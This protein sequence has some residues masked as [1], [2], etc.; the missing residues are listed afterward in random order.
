MVQLKDSPIT[1]WHLPALGQHDVA[2]DFAIGNTFEECRTLSLNT[3]SC[4]PTA[5]AVFLHAHATCSDFEL[6]RKEMVPLKT[7]WGE[8][9]EASKFFTP[10]A[11]DPMLYETYCLNCV[12]QS[13]DQWLPWKARVFHTTR[14]C[15][16]LSLAGDKWHADNRESDG[17]ARSLWA[18]AWQW[19]WPRHKFPANAV[20]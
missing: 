15:F 13:Y 4:F 12:L 9:E 7:C 10:F 1:R 18:C 3:K 2:I 20:T 8:A 5:T 14:L 17:K 16:F 11:N 6:H 19:T